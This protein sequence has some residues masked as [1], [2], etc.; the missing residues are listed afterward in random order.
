MVRKATAVLGLVGGV[1]AATGLW[2]LYQRATT[3]TVPYTVVAD[4]GDVELRRYPSLVVAET[5]APSGNEAFRRLFRYISGANEGDVDISMTAPVAVRDD[6]TEV[7]M[8]GP[9]EVGESGSELPMTAPV[10][11]DTGAA[12]GVRMAFYLPP[13]YDIVSAPTPTDDDVELVAL[14]ERTLAV[15]RFSWRP[16]DRRVARE[17]SRLVETLEEA[18]VPMAG[19]P[20][21]M[22]YDA[23]GTLPFLRR[24]EVAVEVASTAAT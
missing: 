8:T 2:T 23:P 12:G 24:N 6:G 18:S 4:I 21:L 22:G 11:T 19:A 7:P 14:G 5:E 16:T 1:V 3:E 13:E 17:S 9:V 20:F 10:E 15:R